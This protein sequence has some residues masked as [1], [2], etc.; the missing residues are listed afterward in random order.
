MSVPVGILAPVDAGQKRLWTYLSAGALTFLTLYV[1]FRLQ[2]YGPESAIRRFH[3]D[4]LDN[5][6]EDLQRVTERPITSY[7]AVLLRSYVRSWLSSGWSYQ[8]LRM[9]RFP[10]QVRAAVV[11]TP[12]HGAEIPLIWVVEKD[13]RAWKVNADK[14]VTVIHAA[15]GWLPKPGSF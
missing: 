14:T 13:G 5:N 8:L 12:P 11:Y 4:V 15:L 9:E 2:D 7:N 10:D 6:T 3:A 1:F